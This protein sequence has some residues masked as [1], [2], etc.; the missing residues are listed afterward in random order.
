M[1]KRTPSRGL[2][3]AG[4]TLDG[5]GNLRKT[6]KQRRCRGFDVNAVETKGGGR[7]VTDFR[8]VPRATEK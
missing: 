5:R 3:T 1:T 8:A 7:L 6:K 4:G 2:T